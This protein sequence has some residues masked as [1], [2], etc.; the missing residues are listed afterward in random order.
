MYGKDRSDLNFQEV[1]ILRIENFQK[2]DIGRYECH[3]I[4][5]CDDVTA[6][7]FF[8]GA[9]LCYD[10]ELMKGGMSYFYVIFLEDNYTRKI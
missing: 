6:P 10:D 3:V 5:T 8:K 4:T 7:V 2:D 1:S 9:D